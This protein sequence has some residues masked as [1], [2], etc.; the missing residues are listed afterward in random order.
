MIIDFLKHKGFSLKRIIFLLSFFISTLFSNNLLVTGTVVSD[1]QK[2]I[3]ARYMGYVK[4]IRFNIGDK[5]QRNDVLFTMESAEFDIMQSQADLALEQ[6]ELMIELYRSRLDTIRHEQK[7]L[8]RRKLKGGTE[9]NE[10]E[11]IAQNVQAGLSATRAMVK[12]ATEKVKQ[13]ATIMDYLE[14]KAPNAGIIV[15][16]QIR[17]GDLIVPG[18]LAMVLVDLDHLEVEAQVS[19]VDLSK[20]Q[21]GKAVKIDIPSMKFRTTAIVK[22][23]VPSANPMTHTFTVRIAFD[24]GKRKIFPGMYVK[25][26]VPYTE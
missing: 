22:S 7:S 23:V 1:N 5:V 12:N 24:K 25:I 8:K 11:S 18:M 3:G 6:A 2:M 9:W 26:A 20:V 16:K 10:L 17:V 19:E 15:Q 21:K 13:M 14:I 4:E